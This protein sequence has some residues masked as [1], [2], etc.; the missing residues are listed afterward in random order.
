MPR[1]TA[2]SCS[3]TSGAS[4]F[5]AA[6]SSNCSSGSTKLTMSGHLKAALRSRRYTGV[7]AVRDNRWSESIAI[8]SLAFVEKVR[9]ELGIKALH[10]EFEPLGDAYA[11]R[12]RS[13][14][15]ARK[16]TDKNEALSSENTLL[17]NESLETQRHSAVR[18]GN[19]TLKIE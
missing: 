1:A 13:E 14:A 17:W 7:R 18:P 16:F 4:L 11:L 5:N 15:Y 3:V 19:E 6:A 10:R 8:G 12:E 2:I 9:G